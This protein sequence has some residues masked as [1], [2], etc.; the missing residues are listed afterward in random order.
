MVQYPEIFSSWSIFQRNSNA[1]FIHS[2]A[3]STPTSSGS[4]FYSPKYKEKTFPNYRSFFWSKQLGEKVA[5]KPKIKPKMPDS[6]T[7]KCLGSIKS[8]EEAQSCCETPEILCAGHF[9]PSSTVQKPCFFLGWSLQKSCR[10][11]LEFILY[12][13]R[14]FGDKSGSISPKKKSLLCHFKQ[15]W[16]ISKA[17]AVLMVNNL[18]QQ[19]AEPADLTKQMRPS[20]LS[21]SCTEKGE[22]F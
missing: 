11:P 8:V 16:G 14:W 12:P 22:N 3:W 21:H 7:C 19:P 2:R 1:K 18:P 4:N 9:V 6:R 20:G 10:A 15:N 17:K 13:A 5:K